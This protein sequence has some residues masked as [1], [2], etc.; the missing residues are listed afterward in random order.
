MAALKIDRVLVGEALE[1]VRYFPIL[2]DSQIRRTMR[3]L[4]RDSD[5]GDYGSRLQPGF[6]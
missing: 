4:D 5:G 6:A 3:F 1:R 2:V